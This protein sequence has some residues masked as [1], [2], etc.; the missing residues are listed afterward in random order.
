MPIP[1]V[2]REAGGQVQYFPSDLSQPINPVVR[3]DLLAASGSGL[4]R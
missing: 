1:E 4:T 3:F 2:T